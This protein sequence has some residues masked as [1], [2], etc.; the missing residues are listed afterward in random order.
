[1]NGAGGV[2]QHSGSADQSN[3]RLH[4]V[5]VVEQSTFGCRLLPARRHVSARPLHKKRKTHAT[6]QLCRSAAMTSSCP[7]TAKAKGG[8][9][10]GEAGLYKGSTV[11]R[12]AQRACRW[13]RQP[14]LCRLALSVPLTLAIG[15]THN[16]SQRMSPKCLL[17]P[18]PSL[19]RDHPNRVPY[20]ESDRLHRATPCAG[21]LAPHPS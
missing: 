3:C 10:F 2:L 15:A 5:H 21:H 8:R 7:S 19:H 14:K 17:H 9:V 18:L 20:C 12:A 1:M 4:M 11:Q 6:P 16:K 13:G